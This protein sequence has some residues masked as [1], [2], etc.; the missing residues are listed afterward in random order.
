MLFRRPSL[1]LAALIPAVWLLTAAAPQ[2]ASAYDPKWTHRWIA[3]KAIEILQHQFGDQY[4]LLDEW[5]ESIVDG[6]EHEDDIILDGDTDIQTVRLMR[7]FYRPTDGAGLSLQPF[8]VFPNSQEWGAVANDQNE[9]DYT[10]A[11]AA[12]QRGDLDEAFFAL[13]HVVHLTQ[14]ATVPAH[15]HLDDHGPPNGDFYEKWCTSQM[16]SEFDGDLPVP[17]LDAPIPEFDTIEDLFHHTARTSYWRNMVP[18]TLSAPQDD[19]ATGVIVEMF[20]DLYTNITQQWEIPGVGVLDVAFFEDEP[21][22]F[23]L[24]QLDKV[25]MIDRVFDSAVPEEFVYGDNASEVKLVEVM[26]GDLVPV[27]IMSSASAIKHFLDE[28]ETLGPPDGDDTEDPDHPL[29]DDETSACSA[30]GRGGAAPTASLLLLALLFIRRR[31][32]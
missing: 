18:G 25:A 3:R 24:N 8:G 10:D 32:S 9:W 5:A 14:D 31:R 17:D 4:P 26:A 2:T 21:G 29:P 28:A 20:P 1:L 16:R 6:C 23:Y 27:A 7:H 22:Y 11:L 12:Y 15:T 30:A 13:G 19:V